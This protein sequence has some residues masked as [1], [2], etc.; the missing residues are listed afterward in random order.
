MFINDLDVVEAYYAIE[1]L[2][3][4]SYISYVARHGAQRGCPIYSGAD[5]DFQAS[6]PCSTPI[7][8]TAFSFSGH[9]ESSSTELDSSRTRQTIS[10]QDAGFIY[11]TFL[12]MSATGAFQTDYEVTPNASSTTRVAK[13]TADSLDVEITGGWQPFNAV[14]F[15]SRAGVRYHLSHVSIE[16]TREIPENGSDAVTEQA[17]AT[18]RSADG[19]TYFIERTFT[20]NDGDCPSEPLT[21]SMKVTG[22]TS[23]TFTFDGTTMCNECVPFTLSTGGGGQLCFTAALPALPL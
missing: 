22:A 5:N 13:T 4:A 20:R 6:G 9:L 8:A 11:G 21:G 18:V 17:R 15:P 14:L 7:G 19:G 10:A 16:E 3:A 12:A 2:G 23:V 1:A